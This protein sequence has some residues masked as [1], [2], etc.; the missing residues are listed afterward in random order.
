M[1]F[2]EVIGDP[3]S[4]SKSPII[5][6]YWL[7]QLGIDGDYVRQQ[8]AAKDLGDFVSRRRA[9]RQ[10]RG[11]NVTIPHKQAI[12]PLLDRI[13]M[14]AS[15]I[16]AVNCVVPEVGGLAGYNSDIDGVAEALDS[17]ELRDRK[18]AVIGAG[19]GARAVVAYLVQRKAEIVVVARNPAKA[20]EL[21]SLA[22]VRILP[23]AQAAEAFRDSAAIVNATSLGMADADPMPALLLDAVR[24]K[25]ADAVLFD[26]VTTPQNTDFLSCGDRT[27]DGLTML[28]GQARRAFELFFGSTPP[29]D[30]SE[31]RRLLTGANQ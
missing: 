24:A 17:F 27:V 6:K 18:V 16:G 10:W 7:D 31:L 30:D 3:I 9:D 21:R 8:V 25:A 12:M 1:Q 15:A 28:I 14:R 13:D 4:Q 23:L 19:G 5:H 26:M 20:E 2:A 11:C 22:P 29:G